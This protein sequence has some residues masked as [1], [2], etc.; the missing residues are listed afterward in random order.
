MAVSLFGTTYS[1]VQAEYLPQYTIDGTSR[2][3]STNV[4]ALITKYA[5][6]VNAVLRETGIDPAVVTSTAYPQS[7]SHLQHVVCCGVAG[8]LYPAFAPQGRQP[9]GNRWWDE[10]K[11]LLAELRARPQVL[12]DLWDSDTYAGSI[13][14]HVLNPDT[15]IE[16]DEVTLVD[17]DW[18]MDTTEQV[19]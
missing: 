19:F 12:S 3:T 5:A 18:T 9:L 7:Y 15:D 4:G 2:P 11:A 6:L 16:D 14:S 13:G 17:K 1:I 10:W 8:H